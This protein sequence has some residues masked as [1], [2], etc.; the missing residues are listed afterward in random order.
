MCDEDET[1]KMFFLYFFSFCSLWVT[2]WIF[3]GLIIIMHWHLI[4]WKIPYVFCLFKSCTVCINVYVHMHIW[5]RKTI[6]NNYESVGWW[7]TSSDI[8]FQLLS[9]SF[10]RLMWC[11]F[12]WPTRHWTNFESDN[13]IF[14]VYFIGLFSRYSVCLWPQFHSISLSSY[15]TFTFFHF[16]F[17]FG[18]KTKM[19]R[20]LN[21]KL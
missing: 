10:R 12:W 13:S 8:V 18:N 21:R 9:H 7:S 1:N 14:H 6:W 16:F 19:K 11:Y 15:N 4:L 5:Y 17:F 3:I 2:H 20:K